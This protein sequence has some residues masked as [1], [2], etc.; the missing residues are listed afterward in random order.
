M[1]KTHKIPGDIVD[2]ISKAKVYLASHPRV[3]FAYLF[4]GLA[5]GKPS[6]LSDVDIAVYLS[7]GGDVAQEKMEILG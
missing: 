7:E 4:G 3:L 1:I 5:K 2:H 6:P